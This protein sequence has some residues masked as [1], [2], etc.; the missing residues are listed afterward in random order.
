MKMTKRRANHAAQLR[1]RVLAEWRGLGEWRERT[2]RETTAADS[3]LKVMEGLGLGERL[4]SAEVLGAWREIAGDFFAKHAEPRMLKDRILYVS[5][6]Q[7]T[8]HFELDRVW[9]REILAKFKDRFGSRTIKE[10]R[11]RLG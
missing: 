10:I 9:K 4:K 7:P 5:V 6:L 3:V 8:V 11:F 1:A 2:E